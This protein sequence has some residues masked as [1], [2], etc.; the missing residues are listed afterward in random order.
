MIFT[1]LFPVVNER[2]SKIWHGSGYWGP[3]SHPF[4]KQVSTRQPAVRVGFVPLTDAGP[5]VLG[6]TGGAF[7]R[8][9]ADVWLTPEIGWATIRDEMAAG[10]M[11]AAHM[12]APLALAMHRGIG[13]RRT[14]LVVP[15]ILN[16]Q[17]NAITLSRRLMR[18]GVGDAASFGRWVRSRAPQKTKLAVVAR[19]SMHGILLHQW[20][21]RAGLAE[22]RL[23]QTLV[24]PPA[25]MAKSLE[26]GLIDGFCVGEPWNS[27][28]VA[29]G[30]GWVIATS[31][32]LLPDHP[33][34]VLA[35][36][37]EFCERNPDA[38]LALLK[39]LSASS[40]D[41]ETPEG[42]R[43][44]ATVLARPEWLDTDRKILVSA[45]VGPMPA[46]NGSSFPADYF[47]RFAARDVNRPDASIETQ[48]LR[49][50]RD[51]GK[52][53]ASTETGLKTSPLFDPAFHDRIDLP[54]V[55]RG[56]SHRNKRHYAIA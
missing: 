1:N 23:I 50:M 9:G 7:A 35:F 11:E 21:K 16:T 52:R 32:C 36:R 40:R 5:L 31:R 6:Q 24:L 8:A 54:A 20:L 56:K 27:L 42:R 14:P 25:Q 15:W 2:K 17:G 22:S 48:I 38:I 43:M 33:E 3:V 53:P 28:S 18:E 34:K 12:P 49:W 45:L 44:L 46:G 19:Y 37:R 30:S 29:Q 26:A 51:A 10:A 55:P 13:C 4:G 39:G 47:H 41:C